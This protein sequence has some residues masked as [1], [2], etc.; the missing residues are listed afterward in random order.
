M[1][2][3]VVTLRP[4]YGF[5]VSVLLCCRLDFK[6]SFSYPFFTL[7]PCVCFVAFIRWG[8]LAVVLSPYLLASFPV[9]F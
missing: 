7:M 3:T 5:S 4:A 1:P 6:L 2:V 8:V 9:G